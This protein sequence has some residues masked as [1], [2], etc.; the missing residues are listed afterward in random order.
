MVAKALV[1]TRHTILAHLVVTR[2]CNLACAYCNE[3]DHISEPVP[4]ELL[5]RRIDDLSSRGTSIITISGGEPLLHPELADVVAHI[6][7]RG[8]IATLITNG[9]LL[10][11]QRIKKLN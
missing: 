10:S 11:E 3:Y 7:R 2:R 8:I 4:L 1:S 9:Y 5:R 6:R